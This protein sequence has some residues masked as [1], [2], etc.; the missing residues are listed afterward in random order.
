VQSCSILLTRTRVKK[1]RMVG[2]LGEEISVGNDAL[3]RCVEIPTLAEYGRAQSREG[4]GP[5][6]GVFDETSLAR[7][8]VW[9]F[10]VSFDTS[11]NPVLGTDLYFAS[12]YG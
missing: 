7:G 1:S 9:S 11:E 3:P 8:S 4:L 12:K 10:P 6:P 2:F 5:V